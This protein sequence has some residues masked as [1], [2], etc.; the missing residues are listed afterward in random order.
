MLS[1]A[2]AT[3]AVEAAYHRMQFSS[4]FGYIRLAAVFP[5]P[6]ASSASNNS[7][8]HTMFLMICAL[9]AKADKVEEVKARLAEVSKSCEL[10]GV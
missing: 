9:E 6:Q 8:Y 10:F 4:P 2:C 7:Y 1:G 5:G 3:E